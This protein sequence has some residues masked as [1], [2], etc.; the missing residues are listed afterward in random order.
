[1][2]RLRHWWR[3]FRNAA[4]GRRDATTLGVILT[5]VVILAGGCG[6]PPE[7]NDCP[8]SPPGI[9]PAS[10]TG[11]EWR[12]DGDVAALA[13]LTRVAVECIPNRHEAVGTTTAQRDAVTDYELAVTAT[14]KYTV[15]DRAW[16]ENQARSGAFDAAVMFEA[17]SESEVV[18]GSGSA[19][20]TLEIGGTETTV[21]AQISQSLG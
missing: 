13:V 20:M 6:Q 12:N 10:G 2:S 7:E 16:L 17:V 9:V 4:P 21:S 8:P 11:I 1:M 14:V 3:T 5:L 19:S 18:L 15:F